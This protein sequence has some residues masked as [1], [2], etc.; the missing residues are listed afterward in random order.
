MRNDKSRFFTLNLVNETIMFSL[1]EALH[2]LLTIVR[3]G[4]EGFGVTENMSLCY[5]ST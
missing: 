5:E 2:L 4:L 1:R 3:L